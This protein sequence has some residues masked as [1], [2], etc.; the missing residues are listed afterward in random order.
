MTSLQLAILLFA[1]A[2]TVNSVCVYA[3]KRHHIY[4]HFGH[5]GWAM[6][7]VLLTILWSAVVVAAGQLH[8]SLHWSLPALARYVG[9]ISALAASLLFLA[10]AKNLGMGTVLNGNFFGHGKKASGGTFGFLKNPM[11]DSF[12]LAFIAL[13]LVFSEGGYLV[14]AVESYIGLNVIQSS[15]EQIEAAID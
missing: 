15:V 11:Y 8:S 12:V 13:A 14:L 9:Y 2:V 4:G 7:I 5:W 6:H 10:S 1:I 3:Q